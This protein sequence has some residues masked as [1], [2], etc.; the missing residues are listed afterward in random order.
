MKNMKKIGNLTLILIL[1]L[2]FVACSKPLFQK[3]NGCGCP[4]K[5]GMT[6]YMP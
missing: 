4:D 2:C 1:S 6:G 3:K 5:R